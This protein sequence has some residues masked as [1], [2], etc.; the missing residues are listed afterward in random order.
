MISLEGTKVLVTGASSMVG[1]AVVEKLKQRKATVVEVLHENCDLLDYYQTI[2]LFKEERPDYCV[3]AAGYNGN[4]KFNKLYPADIFYNTTIMGLNVLKACA[5][6]QVKKVVSP[7]SSC[8]YRSTDEYLKENDFNNGM[9]DE[10]VEAHGL[11]KK[12]LF[13]FSRQVCKQ[14]DIMAVCT[15]FNTV[16]GPYDS[17]DIEKTKVTGGLIKKF[18]DA[19]NN[20]DQIVECWGTGSPRRELIYCADAAEGL[21]QTLEKYDNIKLPINIGYNED[22]SIRELA[23]LISDVSNFK[24]E[25]YWDTNRPDGQYRKILDS[26]RMKKYGIEIKNKT[27]LREGLTKTMEWYKKN[28]T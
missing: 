1:R 18:V 22:I 15:I 28:A 21:I 23:N 2:E 17:Y 25:T 27:P 12:A 9:P 24:G 26:S 13:Y 4:I 10:T 7:L 6:T 14:Y 16:Y 20:E 19:V 11:S 8:A 3:H 5:L